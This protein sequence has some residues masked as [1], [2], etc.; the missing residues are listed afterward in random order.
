MKS[1]KKIKIKNKIKKGVKAFQDSENEA[2]EQVSSAEQLPSP[3]EL[4][5]SLFSLND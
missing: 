2:L 1:Y 4:S 5:G 3:S